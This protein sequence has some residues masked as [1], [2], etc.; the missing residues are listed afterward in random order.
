LDLR[1]ERITFG[2]KWIREA[3]EAGKLAGRLLRKLM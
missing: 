1:F 2:G 3:R